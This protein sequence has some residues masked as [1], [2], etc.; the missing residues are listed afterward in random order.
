MSQPPI[1]CTLTAHDLACGAA[2]L[3]PGLAESAESVQ[4]V[5]NGIRFAFAPKEGIVRNVAGVIERERLCCQFLRFRLEVSASVGSI[6]LEIDG[7]SGTSEFLAG[8]HPSFRVA[9]A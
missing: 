7:P 2:D 6:T 5:P 9:N 4:L 8:L 1:A 3:L